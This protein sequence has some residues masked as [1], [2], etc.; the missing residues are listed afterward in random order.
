M[1]LLVTGISGF[2]GKNIVENFS[3]TALTQPEWRSIELFGTDI[4]PLKNM[5]TKAGNFIKCDLCVYK[6]IHQ[7]INKIKPDLMLHLASYSNPALSKINVYDTIRNN[8]ISSLNLLEAVKESDLNTKILL[9]GSFDQYLKYNEGIKIVETHSTNPLSPYAISKQTQ[10]YLGK[11]YFNEYGLKVYLTR[12]F[13]HF[14]PHQKQEFV[15]GFIC[16]QFAEILL[17]FRKERIIYLG[18]PDLIR[19]FLYV[20]DAIKA[21]FYILKYAK[22]NEI[23]N[24]CSNEPLYL[25]DIVDLIAKMY[26]IN[27]KIK[28][29]P[30]WDRLDE[31]KIVTGSNAKLKKH[32]GWKPEVTLEQ[33]LYK[34]V[35]WWIDRLRSTHERGLRSTLLGS[36]VIAFLGFCALHNV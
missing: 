26:D 24:V 4:L 30:E 12:S 14:G 28:R 8:I 20:T 5:K 10:E 32:T 34:T 9:I 1:R 31:V 13:N 27:V 25:R 35:E 33:G 2:V 6:Q 18:N 21:Y 15:I 17:N 23:Y 3:G 22:P 11:F 19:E 36:W 7:I 29:I 16:R